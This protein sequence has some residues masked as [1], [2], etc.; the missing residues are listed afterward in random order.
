M[1]TI[2]SKQT[3]KTMKPKNS[4]KQSNKQTTSNKESSK[5]QQENC[6]NKTQNK[7]APVIESPQNSR[8]N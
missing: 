8:K 3:N 7:K 1:I 2:R 5:Q 4:K 6:I